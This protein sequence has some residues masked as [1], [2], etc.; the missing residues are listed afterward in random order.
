[1]TDVITDEKMS[2]VDL[3]AVRIRSRGSRSLS[4]A[5]N[6]ELVRQ[7]AERAL[8]E[9]LQLTGEGGLLAELTERVVEAALEGELDAHACPVLLGRLADAFV[10]ATTPVQD[11]LGVPGGLASAL[12]DQFLGRLPGDGR[13]EVRGHGPIVRVIGVL[14]IDDVG[15]ALQRGDDIVFRHDAVP[16]PVRQRRA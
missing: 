1:V 7:L 15:H 5:S 11:R 2:P 14:T 16:Q 10:L 12:E 8:A 9:G 3:D 13:V 4:E 6:D